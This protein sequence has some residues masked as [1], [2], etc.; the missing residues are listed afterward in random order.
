MHGSAIKALGKSTFEGKTIGKIGGYLCSFSVPE[1]TDSYDDFFGAGRTDFDIKE[2]QTIQSP[3]YYHHSLDDNVRPIKIGNSTLSLDSNGVPI[4][5]EID[6]SN[7][8]ALKQYERAERGELGWSS[9]TAAHLVRR[10]KV[11]TKTGRT[12]NLITYWPL[13]MDA[14]LTPT[15]ADPRN[16]AVAI[17]SISPDAGEATPVPSNQDDLDYIAYLE[18]ELSSVRS[19]LNDIRL[20]AMRQEQMHYIQAMSG[21]MGN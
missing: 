15:P 20:T 2:G 13:G 5:A 16:V 18:S 11:A 9:G 10:E 3:V 7:P 1:K 21:L 4:E 17:K 14:S 8:F 12:A 19:E 6:L